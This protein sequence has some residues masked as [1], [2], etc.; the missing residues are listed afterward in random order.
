LV[1]PEIAKF[2]R[3]CTYD[4]AG[5]GWSDVGPEPR[6]SQQFASE[7]HT[8]LEKADEGPPYILVAHSYGGHTIRI[9][10]Q[11]HPEEVFGMVLVDARLPTDEIPDGSMS[12]GELKL[13]EF[14][15]RCGF[16]RLMG[17]QVMS[18]MAPTLLEKIPDYPIPI[19]WAPK[20]FENNRLQNEIS[21]E[22]DKQVRETGPFGDLPLSVIVPEIPDMFSHLPPEEMAAAEALTRT[23]QRELT[24]LSTNSQFLI[25]EGSE[26]NIHVENPDIII[27]VVR[28]M[29][30]E[31]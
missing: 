12:S 24:N 30:G 15:A 10:T 26:H 31:Y 2:G 5:L 8:L 29:M 28:E 13:W 17:K 14:L 4:R 27:D 23:G 21:A 6:S 16:F 22:S 25:A 18:V 7:L 9:Y 20:L 3:V 1:Q 11:A 19:V